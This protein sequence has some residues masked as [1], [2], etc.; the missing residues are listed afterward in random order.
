[1]K[2]DLNAYW[3]LARTNRR[4]ARLLAAHQPMPLLLPLDFPSAAIRR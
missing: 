1:M 4:L 3:A 2:P